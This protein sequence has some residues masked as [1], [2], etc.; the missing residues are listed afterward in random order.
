MDPAY[1][2][3]RQLAAYWSISARTLQRWRLEGRGPDYVKLGKC[4]RYPFGLQQP[5][6]RSTW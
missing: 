1:M 3:E 5:S 4:V 2:S 6:R